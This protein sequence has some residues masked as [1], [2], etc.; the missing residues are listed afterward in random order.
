[1]STIPLTVTAIR[2]LLKDEP[3]RVQLGAAVVGSSD[4]TVTLVA[5]DITKIQSGIRVEHDDATGE[6]RRVLSVDGD[7]DEFE[8]ERGYLG[9]T[10]AS[11]SNSTYMVVSPRF[12]YDEVS[13]AINMVL[14][15][16]LL[17]AGIYDILERT[18]TSSATTNSY[19][20]P[21]ANV[22]EVLAVYQKT[23]S[24]SEPVWLIDFE[25]YPR[26]VDTS[27]YGTGKMVTIRENLG[28]PGTDTYYLSTKEKLTITT[29]TTRQERIVQ[30]LACA[31]LI[32]WE[33]VRRLAGPTNQGDRTV[34]VNQMAQTGSYYRSLA[35]PLMKAEVS[36]LRSLNPPKKNWLW[37]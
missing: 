16:E 30:L 37:G 17:S 7:N 8:A 13:Q 6:Q 15:A 31:N 34:N 21:S 22:E 10:A 18:I 4:E 24:M 35:R 29:L 14:D 25:R 12:P 3:V 5:G 23:S 27:L 2:R 28:V 36:D 9:S 11:H 1:V 19:N 32:E 26:N 33:S 20:S